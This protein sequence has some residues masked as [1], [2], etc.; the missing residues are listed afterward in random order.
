MLHYITSREMVSLDTQSSQQLSGLKEALE[1]SLPLI[2]QLFP[3]DV[4][5][6]L[7][8]TEKFLH[9]LSGRT[10]DIRLQEGD[11]VPDTSGLRRAMNSGQFASADVDARVYG[12]PF[13]SNTLP[14]RDE[15]DRIIGAITLG[16]SLENQL[17]LTQAAEN[18]AVGSGEV[19]SATDNIAASATQLNSEIQDLK[20]L[21]EQ[22]VV[23]LK[24]TDEMLG[25]IKRVADNSRLL[26]I[27]ASIEA[28]HA[29]E[30][31]RGFSVVASEMRK[32]ADSSASSAK[33]IEEILKTIQ[34]NIARLDETLAACLEQSEQQAAA[35]EQIAA[36]MEQLLESA[37]DI[38]G[39]ARLI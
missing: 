15:Q 26:S 36:S 2:Q 27:N 39:I 14:L 18:L 7:T 38:R 17:I 21:G 12:I 5:F 24:H 11:A 4:M 33:E 31:G 20:Q 9:Y 13:K 10:L 29:G 8:D 23:H 34:G 32:M 37:K 3:M 6:A 22:I 1:Q 19:R 35:T 25:F 16:I 30:H 28:A